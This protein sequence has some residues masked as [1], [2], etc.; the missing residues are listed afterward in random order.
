MSLP[1]LLPVVGLAIGGVMAVNALAGADKFPELVSGARAFA[2]EAVGRTRLDK[3]A[4]DAASAA[5]PAVAA[6][7]PAQVCAPT[8]AELAKEAGLSPA[9][10]RILQNL[11]ER[12]GQLD[13]REQDLSTQIALL[14]AAETKLD[15]KLKA[16]NAVKDE[17]QNLLK[18]GDAKQEAEVARMTKV[19]ESMKPKNAAERLVVLDDAVRLPI[20]AKMKERSLSAILAQMPPDEAK[21]LTESLARRYAALQSLAAAANAPVAANAAAASAPAAAQAPQQQ[22]KADIPP[23]KPAPKAAPR[24]KPAPTKMA[25]AAPKPPAP[26]AAAEPEP[27]LP[28][29]PQPYTPPAPAAPTPETKAG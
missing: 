27:Q 11:G 18:A 24:K 6:A 5:T 26:K 25:A 28:G 16:M 29:K 14:A 9:E 3:S 19:F 21:R 8:A 15:A 2:E 22:A 13:Q 12:R 1:R 23:A 4:P 7:K 17:V 20:A 10:L